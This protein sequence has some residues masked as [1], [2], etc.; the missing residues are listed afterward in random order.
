MSEVPL[1]ADLGEDDARHRAR[2]S[3]RPSAIRVKLEGAGKVGER[4][5]G[6]AGIRDPYTIA[7][8]D[9][10]IEWARQQV[11][12][13]FGDAGYELHYTVYGR[14]GVMGALEPLRDD[15]RHELGIA[16]AGRRAD[17]GDGRG[18]LHDRHPP[19]VL[20]AAAR[21]E[22]HGGLGRLSCSTR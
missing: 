3:S 9:A 4:Y 7:H 17:G 6:I 18:G 10:V 19:A 12:E 20:R 21:C 8:I 11:R 1:R 15:R 2:A 14:D 5:V 13:R 16:G 22:G